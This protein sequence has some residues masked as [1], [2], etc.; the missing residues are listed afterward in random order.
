[1]NKIKKELNKWRD[2][3]YSWTER[4]HGKEDSIF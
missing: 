1:M 3:P 2:I 4:V